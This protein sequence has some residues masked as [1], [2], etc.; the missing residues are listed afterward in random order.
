MWEE[1]LPLQTIYQVF[2]SGHEGNFFEVWKIRKKLL[3][4]EEK[5]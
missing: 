5:G 4:L 1:Y 3:Q 2:Q